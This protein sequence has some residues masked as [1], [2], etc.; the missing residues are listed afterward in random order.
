VGNGTVRPV[1]LVGIENT[2]RRRDLSGPTENPEDKKVAPRVGGSAAFR[3]F[4]RM[5]LIPL[6]SAKYRTTRERAIIGES[7]AGL[8]TVETFFLDRIS[9]IPTL[10]STRVSGGT[11]ATSSNRRSQG[12]AR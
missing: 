7:L 12:C 5:E 1:I 10:R 11:T 9:S 8:F 3:T 6:I 4:L 2:E